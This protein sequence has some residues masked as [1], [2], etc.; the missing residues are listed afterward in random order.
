[1][2]DVRRLES[3]RRDFVANVSHELRTPIASIRSG[4]ETLRGGAAGDPEAASRFLEIIERN[5][6]RL[7]R[8]VE[9]LLDLSRIESREFRLDLEEV[10]V[11]PFVE[12]LLGQHRGRAGARGVRLEAALPGDLA[13]RADRRALEQVLGN[14]VDNALK[15]CPS[16]ASVT[17]RASGEGARVRITVEDTGPGIE[18]RHLPR[19]FER[20]YRVDAGRSRELG[21]TGLGLSIVKH[22][23]EAMGGAVGV[24]SELGRGTRFSFTVPK[25]GTASAFT[26]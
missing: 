18:A 12:H 8:L 26:L 7:S 6:E 20:F 17:V 9:D 1:V 13:V 4:A 2:T 23:V 24:E 15:Y 25:A 10:A 22:L 16:G 11:A 3:L 21:G 14:L 19:L 5:A